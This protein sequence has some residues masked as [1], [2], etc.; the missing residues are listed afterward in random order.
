MRREDE[1]RRLEAARIEGRLNVKIKDRSGE[2]EETATKKKDCN[3]QEKMIVIKSLAK[4]LTF[5]P[6]ISN[7]VLLVFILSGQT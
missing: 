1:V 4:Y 3:A 6:E 7:K 5:L 2:S